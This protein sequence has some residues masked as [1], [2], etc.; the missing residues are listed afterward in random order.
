MTTWRIWKASLKE[1]FGEQLSFIQWQETVTARL[2]LAD[3]TLP[4]YAFAKLRVI[5]RCPVSLTDKKGLNVY[6]RNTRDDQLATA[7]AVTAPE[8]CR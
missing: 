3:E 4:S 8:I 6:P 1:S 5:S 7:I 2:Q